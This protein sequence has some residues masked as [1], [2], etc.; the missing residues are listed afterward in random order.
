MNQ[1]VTFPVKEI[2]TKLKNTPFELR[3]NTVYYANFSK[4]IGNFILSSEE[5]KI[6][7]SSINQFKE[8]HFN[9]VSLVETIQVENLLKTAQYYFPY[10]DFS[11][12][13]DRNVSLSNNLISIL[14]VEIS[15]TN[16]FIYLDYNKLYVFEIVTNQ[17]INDFLVQLPLYEDNQILYSPIF[18]DDFGIEENINLDDETKVIVNNI[19]NQLQQLN[20]TGQFLAILPFIE[21]QIKQYKNQN[22][23]PLSDLYIDEDCRIYLKDYQNREIKL[24]HLTKSLYF[25]FLMKGS[26][27]LDGLEN[28]KNELFT[29]YKHI[30]NQENLDKMEESIDKLVRNENNEVFVHFSRIKSAFCKEIDKQIALNYYIRGSKNQPKSIALSKMRTNIYTLQEICFPN[31]KK[32]TSY[33]QDAYTQANQDEALNL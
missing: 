11:L 4:N 5:I 3:T 22:D 12:F 2:E 32:F 24:S 17:D 25:L 23:F 31:N 16:A 13:N 21:N 1:I 18:D 14:G 27:H 8:K 10:I 26:I 19:S 7:E 33:S 28:Y 30:S 6:E 15:F 9:Y 29:L 20:K